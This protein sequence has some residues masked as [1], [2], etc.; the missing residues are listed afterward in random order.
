MTKPPKAATIITAVLPGVF[1]A[2]C[3]VQPADQNDPRIA[4]AANRSEPPVAVKSRDA[5]AEPGERDIV[6]R[7]REP[8]PGLALP[9]AFHG[10]W[11]SSRAECRGRVWVL[12]EPGG[13][14]APDSIAAFIEPARIVRQTTPDGVP[15]ATITV[16]VEL[17]GEDEELYRGRVRMS[18]AGE[19]LYMSNPDIVSEAEHWQLRNVW[20]TGSRWNARDRPAP[21][22]ASLN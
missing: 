18:R 6:D 22:P 3:S 19:H 16:R 17:G 21:A 7:V 10:H 14:R 20:C 8:D 12:I 9:A 1:A 15:A 2:A 5:E 13:Y 4:E 11:A